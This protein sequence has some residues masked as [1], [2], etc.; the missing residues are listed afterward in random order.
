VF[1]YAKL[2]MALRGLA[3]RYMPAGTYLRR[4]VTSLRS[5]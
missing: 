4:A 2:G 3:R 1:A 5:Q